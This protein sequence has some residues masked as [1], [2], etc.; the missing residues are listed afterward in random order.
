M[1]NQKELVKWLQAHREVVMEKTGSNH[2]KIHF[3]GQVI[4]AA[5]T[6]GRGRGTMNLVSQ[7]R[8]AGMDIPRK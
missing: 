5:G 1:M 6:G 4:V 8:R 2:W 3:R 7:L